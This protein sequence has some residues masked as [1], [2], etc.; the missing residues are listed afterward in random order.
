M[1]LF[2]SMLFQSPPRALAVGAKLTRKASPAVMAPPEAGAEIE[3]LSRTEAAT[4]DAAAAMER[5]MNI[6]L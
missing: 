2:A 5:G 1:L 6:L 4:V 3:T